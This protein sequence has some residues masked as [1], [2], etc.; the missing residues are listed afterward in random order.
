LGIRASA[1]IGNAELAHVLPGHG[2]LC[3]SR[4]VLDHFNEFKRLV[5]TG[6]LRPSTIKMGIKA[7]G[8]VLRLA[9][10]VLAILETKDIDTRHFF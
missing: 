5:D 9:Y 1:Y 7:I 3:E 2:I 4:G 6:P 8:K 10:I